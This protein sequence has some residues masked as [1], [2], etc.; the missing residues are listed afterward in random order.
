MDAVR[1]A[2]SEHRL[3]AFGLLAAMQAFNGVSDSISAMSGASE[4]NKKALRGVTTGIQEALAAG[5][6]LK[7]GMEMLGER[8]AQFAGPAGVALGTFVLFGQIA[9]ANNERLA[10]L[11]TAFEKQIGL[12]RDLGQVSDAV[13]LKMLNAQLAVAKIQATETAQS[14]GSSMGMIWAALIG[15]N[16]GMIQQRMLDATNA[17]N[18]VLDIQKT[19]NALQATIDKKL[20]ETKKSADELAKEQAKSALQLQ[21]EQAG[22]VSALAQIEHQN[23]LALITDEFEKR[24]AEEEDRHNEAIKNIQTEAAIAGQ[25]SNQ[26]ALQSEMLRNEKALADI[27]AARKAGI[28][29]ADEERL[30]A[31][32]ELI[33]EEYSLGKITSDSAIKQLQA[34]LAL[35]TDAK[36]RLKIEQAIQHV[37]DDSTKKTEQALR[38]IGE[39]VSALQN[40]MSMLNMNTNT[41]LGQSLEGLQK[42]LMIIEAIKSVSN[43]VSG[44]ETLLGIGAVL[45]APFTGGA[46]LAGE[47][48]L[49]A[50]SGGYT[51]DGGRYDPAGIVH[52]GEV[53]FEKP[54][55][56]KVG[57][58]RMLA[59]RAS[60][61]STPSTS[62]GGN[63]SGG[64]FVS[65]G[66]NNAIV[67]EIR[68]LN[69]KLSSATLKADRSGL[70]IAWDAENKNRTRLQY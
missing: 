40:L 44:F 61:Q 63:Y 51:G 37:E 6:G 8:F 38:N 53:V 30:N 23:Q 4:D 59:M 67:S 47:L 22:G 9:K 25:L 70:W 52:R 1:G 28:E 41:F 69:N 66:N 18:K 27:D 16:Q 3:M 42:I 20:A 57:V 14:G 46:S 11:D 55:V 12:M 17:S 32:I 26:P 31:A 15:G 29:K 54:I 33:K 36:E 39:G 60:L 56:D 48:P 13:Y 50:A 21:G 65:G 45:A 58:N 49:F 7:F 64:G 19:I 5:L 24:K 2:R 34:K 35:T 68:A 10:D 43:A 62:F